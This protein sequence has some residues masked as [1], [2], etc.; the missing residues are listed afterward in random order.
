ME[1]YENGRL[2]AIL[3]GKLSR[4]LAILRRGNNQMKYLRKLLGVKINKLKK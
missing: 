3:S 4:D 2:I 1:R